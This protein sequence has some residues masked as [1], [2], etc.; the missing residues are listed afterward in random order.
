MPL[1]LALGLLAAV[2]EYIPNIGP[3]LATIPAVL[4][5]LT[6]GMHQAIYVLMLYLVV[7]ILES[8][9]LTPFILKR[10]VSLPPALTIAA[11]VLFGVLFGFLGLLFA[12]PLAAVLLILVKQVYVKHTFGDD[13][14]EVESRP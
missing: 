1:A 9:L 2:L 10:A 14:V 12:T 13:S 11:L 4:I 6:Q 5:A 3:T 8:Y 7:Q